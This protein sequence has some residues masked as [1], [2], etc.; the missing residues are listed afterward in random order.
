MKPKPEKLRNKKRVVDVDVEV[1]G[2]EAEKSPSKNDVLQLLNMVGFAPE[3]AVEAAATL[4]QLFVRAINYRL[5]CLTNKSEAK[6]QAKRIN[7]EVELEIRNEAKVNDEKIT[8]NHIKAKLTLDKQVSK[9]EHD[10]E[11]SETFDEY[12]KLVVEA[13]RIQRDSLQVIKGLISDEI[14]QGRALD[15]EV[16]TL[17][18]TRKKLKERF[19]GE[20]E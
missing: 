5:E 10:L 20:D 19:P 12:S 17:S 2:I 1:E 7:A 8:E 15:Q 14:R 18:A 11:R 3:N 13:F 4:P 9:A 16:E 6:L